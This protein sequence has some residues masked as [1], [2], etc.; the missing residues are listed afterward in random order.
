MVGGIDISIRYNWSSGIRVARCWPI[1]SRLP[2]EGCRRI[3]LL[4]EYMNKCKDVVV[5]HNNNP[6]VTSRPCSYLSLEAVILTRED[7]RFN[8]LGDVMR[9]NRGSPQTNMNMQLT[10]CALSRRDSRVKVKLRILVT[11]ASGRE[12]IDSVLLCCEPGILL[13]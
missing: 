4:F 8:G 6:L 3:E 5:W 2:T 7:R 12:S 9:L 10:Q 1:V 13:T 11:I